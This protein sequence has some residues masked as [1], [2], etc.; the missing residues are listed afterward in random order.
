MVASSYVLAATVMS[1]CV[2]I[3]GMPLGRRGCIL[4]GDVF[5]VLGAALQATAF[6]LPHIIVAR[7]LCV[8]FETLPV[9]VWD[10]F[11]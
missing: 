8:S 11:C 4:L 6:S 3:I 2:F 10:S 1:A 9:A 5:V 7:C